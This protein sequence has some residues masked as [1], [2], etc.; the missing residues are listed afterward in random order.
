VRALAEANDL[1][2]LAMESV[3]TKKGVEL[4]EFDPLFL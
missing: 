2:F 4:S 3:T 1:F